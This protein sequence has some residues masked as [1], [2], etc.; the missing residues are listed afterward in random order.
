MNLSS[1][2]VSGCSLAAAARGRGIDLTIAQR[3]VTSNPSAELIIMK[4]MMNLIAITI[5]RWKLTK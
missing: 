2:I 4:S 1:G 3:V 5:L